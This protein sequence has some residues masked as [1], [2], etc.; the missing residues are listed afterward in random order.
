MLHYSSV[1]RH[2]TN[3]VEHHTGSALHGD[4]C[5]KVPQGTAPVQCIM[6]PLNRNKG[7][8]AP[9]QDLRSTAHLMVE[10]GGKFQSNRSSMCRENQ[11]TV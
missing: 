5:F 4:S 11:C 6:I 3:S 2:R 10:I 7:C 8:G 1:V 9:L